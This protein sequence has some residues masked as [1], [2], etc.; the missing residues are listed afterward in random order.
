MQGRVIELV[1]S[2]NKIAMRMRFERL[3]PNVRRRIAL[4][5]NRE[6]G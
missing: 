5:V 6:V 1:A 2:E 4:W 3:T